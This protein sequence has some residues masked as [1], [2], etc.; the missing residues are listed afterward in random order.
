V[1]GLA[2]PTAFGQFLTALR[3]H[4]WVVYAKPPFAGPTQVLEYRSAELATKPRPLH[5][6]RG[7]LQ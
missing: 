7:D 5:P 3:A 2:E 1:A 6:P 4:D